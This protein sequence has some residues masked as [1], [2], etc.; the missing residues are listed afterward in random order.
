MVT[1]LHELLAETGQ[2]APYVLVGHSLGGTLMDLFARTYPDEVVGL[3]LVDSRHHE[4]SS[5]CTAEFGAAS[6]GIPTAEEIA[7]APRPIREEALALATTEQQLSDAP[8]FPE[9]PLAVIVAG[10]VD[11][12][13][14]QAQLWR[15][16]QQDY[17]DMAPGSRL[18]VAEHSDHG[19]PGQ[20]PEIV[21]DTV[22]DIVQ[23]ASR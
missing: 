9:I 2:E 22:L 18:I 19:I 17:A 8:P 4:F 20:Q 10:I 12:D 16:T 3:V 14:G 11:G 23:G 15:Q 6:C 13:P 21:I 1:E 5:R 7:G